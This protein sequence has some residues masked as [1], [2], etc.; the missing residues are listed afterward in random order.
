MSSWTPGKPTIG[1]NRSSLL[2]ALE[3]V[4]SV[5]Q[6]G[7]VTIKAN[8]V[9]IESKG[10]VT[11]KGAAKVV[12]ESSGAFDLKTGGV[13]DLRGSIVKLNNG[14]RPLARVGDQVAGA[15]PMGTIV[16]GNPTT[17]A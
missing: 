17:M 1:V 10:T 7:N 12:I 4:L 9:T 3:K 2:A 13:V 14:S 6:A 11:I 15:G 8:N 5:D 16:G